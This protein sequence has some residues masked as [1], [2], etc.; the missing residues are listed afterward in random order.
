MKFFQEAVR[1]WINLAE[2][3]PEGARKAAEEAKNLKEEEVGIRLIRSYPVYKGE[4]EAQAL[5]RTLAEEAGAAGRRETE[6][7]ETDRRGNGK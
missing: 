5:K 4:T 3:D 6:G 2:N 1:Y 7:A